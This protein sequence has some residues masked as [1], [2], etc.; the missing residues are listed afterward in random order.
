MCSCC[1]R[2]SA[3]YTDPYQPQSGPTSLLLDLYYYMT[4]SGSSLGLRKVHRV[5]KL[6]M[7][8]CNF[9]FF[10]PRMY[11]LIL[12]RNVVV[13]CIHQLRSIPSKVVVFIQDGSCMRVL[14]ILNLAD[15]INLSLHPGTG[16]RSQGYSCHKHQSSICPC[17]VWFKLLVSV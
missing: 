8:T 2:R 11:S 1:S 6:L 7:L 4:H 13:V 9:A 3:R 14:I 15:K 5:V 12:L 17:S 10:P 16:I